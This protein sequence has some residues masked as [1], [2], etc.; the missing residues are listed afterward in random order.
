MKFSVGLF[1]ELFGKRMELE[2]PTKDGRVV[3]R[4]V[5]RKWFEKMR[6]DGKMSR[7]DK[8]VIRVHMLDVA[9]GYY[10][11]T[12]V[13]G[14]DVAEETVKKFRH[15]PTDALYAMTSFK[16]GK[17]ETHVMLKELWYETKVRLDALQ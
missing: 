15:T 1:D 2:V 4:S 8:P 10:V 7:I 3:K 14:R 13:V 5:T 16:D 17:P 9:Q 12:W 6:A 11:A